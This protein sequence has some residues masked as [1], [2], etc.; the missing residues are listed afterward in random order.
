MLKKAYES[1]NKDD[2]EIPLRI[3]LED[4]IFSSIKLQEQVKQQL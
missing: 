3:K 1:L 2:E 4:A